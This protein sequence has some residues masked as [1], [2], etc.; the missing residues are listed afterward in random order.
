VENIIGKRP[1][2]EKKVFLEETPP[3]SPANIGELN[4]TNTATETGKGE[5]NV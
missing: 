3:V 4:T 2:E 1:F 5:V